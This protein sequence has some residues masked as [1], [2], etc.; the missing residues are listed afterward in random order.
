MPSSKPGLRSKL[1]GCWGRS[2][3]VVEGS[4]E[5]V[6]MESKPDVVV[7]SKA[8]VDS[9]VKAG[10]SLRDSVAVA[11]SGIVDSCVVESEGSSVLLV[12]AEGLQG[13]AKVVEHKARSWR[14]G[15]INLMMLVAFGEQLFEGMWQP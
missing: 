11:L 7:A 2:D 3:V 13:D 5:V 9:V 15:C 6:E 10:G 14:V 4:A 12:E 8:S 1:L